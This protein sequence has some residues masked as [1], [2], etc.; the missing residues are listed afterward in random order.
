MAR[1]TCLKLFFTNQ[2]RKISNSTKK[3]LAK[4]YEK[5]KYGKM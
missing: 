4:T 1:H 2:M 5:R 3:F